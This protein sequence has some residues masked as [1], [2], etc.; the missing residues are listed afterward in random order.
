VKYLNSAGGRR[1][2]GQPEAYRDAVLPPSVT[3]RVS[4]EAGTGLGWHRY[5]GDR[6]TIVSVEEFGASGA[7][8][9][10]HS[11][12]GITVD[13]VVEAVLRSVEQAGEL[14][15][16]SAGQSDSVAELACVAVW[17]LG[18]STTRIEG[19]AK[20]SSPPEPNVLGARGGTACSHNDARVRN[21]IY[22]IATALA[23]EPMPPGALN[24]ALTKNTSYTP[25][26]AQSSARS[27]SHQSSPS[28]IPNWPMS[29]W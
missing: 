13:A 8:D 16:Q 10:V 25:S 2:G 23:V 4:V 26:A 19:W 21:T 17:L 20:G 29:I 3:A 6:G 12:R 18:S 14:T 1:F 24:G 11:A 28:A 27:L 15:I 9:L 5:V 7:G 22:L